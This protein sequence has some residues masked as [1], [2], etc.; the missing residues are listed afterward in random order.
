MGARSYAPVELGRATQRLDAAE[1]AF[2]QRDLA[3]AERL[4]AQAMLEAQ[5]AQAR[6]RSAT[7]RE[8]VRVRTNENTRLRQELLGEGMLR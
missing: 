5:L 8:Q 3:A 7:L 4:A 1:A 6:S 2:G